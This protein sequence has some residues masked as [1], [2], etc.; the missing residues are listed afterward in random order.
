MPIHDPFKFRIGASVDKR[1]GYK[2]PGIVVSAFDNSGGERRYVVESTTLPYLLHIFNESQL[3]LRRVEEPLVTDGPPMIVGVRYVDD[4]PESAQFTTLRGANA[5][6]NREWDVDGKITLAFR[7]N[8]LAGEVGE[9]CNII[10]KLERERIGLVGTRATAQQLAYE[11]A[12]V[13]ICADLIAMDAG[14]DLDAAVREKFNATSKK[15]GLKTRFVEPPRKDDKLFLKRALAAEIIV[16]K[17]RSLLD[18]IRDDLPR[19]IIEEDAKAANVL[20]REITDALAKSRQPPMT[21][22]ASHGDGRVN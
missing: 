17:L 20:L 9:A 3:C 11:L 16:A 7:G 18:R 10:K 13:V 6:R 2:F 4:S 8:E 15:V 21:D 5:A 14:I 12:D 19:M 1:D 22:A